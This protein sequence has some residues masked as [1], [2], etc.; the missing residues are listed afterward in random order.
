[1]AVDQSYAAARMSLEIDE[2][3]AG[4]R[5]AQ[6]RL[7]QLEEVQQP[8]W[9]TPRLIRD[10]IADVSGPLEHAALDTR[11]AWVRDLFERIDADSREGPPP[12]LPSLP[13]RGAIPR[14]PAGPRSA[15]SWR[16]RPAA[17]RHRSSL[18]RLQA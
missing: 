3:A 9:V 8:M 11:V 7:E 18:P 12:D 10:T 16:V 15:S 13:P 5:Q 1:M 14:V 2:I 6:L 4:L 17:P